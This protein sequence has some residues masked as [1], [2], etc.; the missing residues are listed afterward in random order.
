MLLSTLQAQIAPISFSPISCYCGSK[1]CLALN[2]PWARKAS[3][4]AS[5]SAHAVVIEVFETLDFGP[6]VAM[7][8]SGS[9]CFTCSN[10]F[11]DACK[12]KRKEFDCVAPPEVLKALMTHAVNFTLQHCTCKPLPSFLMRS[13]KI[14]MAPLIFLFG[15]NLSLFLRDFSVRMSSRISPFIVGAAFVRF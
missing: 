15:L 12:P 3:I 7:T 10:L 8:V 1:S 4:W 11:I 5:A 14:A 9:H 6:Y 2:N 13:F